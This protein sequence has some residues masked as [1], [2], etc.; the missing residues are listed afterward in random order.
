[1][2][3]VSKKRWALTAVLIVLLCFV[4][5]MAKAAE[6]WRVKVHYKLIDKTV[7]AHYIFDTEQS[8]KDAKIWFEEISAWHGMN[9]YECVLESQCPV[10]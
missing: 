7:C 5:F 9:E 1:M 10:N 8:C 4:M 3:R 6:S 2:N